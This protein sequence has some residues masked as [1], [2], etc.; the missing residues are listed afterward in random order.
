[1][2]SCMINDS[3]ID[4]VT[5][6]M[7]A[8]QHGYGV[9]QLLNRL[10]NAGSLQ[11]NVIS[12][13]LL[14]IEKQKV[15]ELRPGACPKNLTIHL[16][17]LDVVQIDIISDVFAAILSGSIGLIFPG[18]MWF[19]KGITYPPFPEIPAQCQNIH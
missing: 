5:L 15:T 12:G 2:A 18:T 8:A 3:I 10:W 7:S 11:L 4:F 9:V 1:M 19:C 17:L 6:G 16:I 14:L 13:L